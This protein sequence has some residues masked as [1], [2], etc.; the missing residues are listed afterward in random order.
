MDDLR[1]SGSGT[2]GVVNPLRTKTLRGERRANAWARETRRQNGGVLRC[3]IC[4]KNPA[5]Y[6]LSEWAEFESKKTPASL[7]NIAPIC[8][9]CYCKGETFYSEALDVPPW[10]TSRI[11]RIR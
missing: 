6:L 2:F 4:D 3:E 1:D 11:K 10:H 8:D 9:D 5:E 7:V